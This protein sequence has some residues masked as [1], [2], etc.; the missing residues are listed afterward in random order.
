[1]TNKADQT[2]LGIKLA[3][4]LLDVSGRKLATRTYYQASIPPKSEARI[5]L[6]V[7]TPNVAGAKLV[8]IQEDQRPP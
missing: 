6:A 7:D 2:R 8:S 3:L 5:K 4:N 1:L